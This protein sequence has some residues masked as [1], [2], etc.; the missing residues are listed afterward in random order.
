MFTVFIISNSD[1][2]V[3]IIIII[4]IIVIIIIVIIVISTIRKSL[5]LKHSIAKE[6]GVEIKPVAHKSDILYLY[7]HFFMKIRLIY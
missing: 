3:I 4:V 1:I 5:L 6:S 2:I 7:I